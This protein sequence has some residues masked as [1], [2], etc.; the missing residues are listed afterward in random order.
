MQWGKF[1]GVIIFISAEQFV[2]VI[3]FLKHDT[4]E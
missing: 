1:I 3:I 4:S 2:G